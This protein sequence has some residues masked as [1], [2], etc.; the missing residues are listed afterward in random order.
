MAKVVCTRTLWTVLVRLSKEVQ[1]TKFFRVPFFFH[2]PNGTCRRPL[3]IHVVVSC[4]AEIPCLHS[5]GVRAL[6]RGLIPTLMGVFPF[7]GLTFM[8]YDVRQLLLADAPQLSAHS[9]C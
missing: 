8:G 7:A 5:E 4:A 1:A 2:S 3:P 6:Y 9:F